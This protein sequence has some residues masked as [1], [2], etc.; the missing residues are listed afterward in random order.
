MIRRKGTLSYGIKN[1]CV[2]GSGIID[3]RRFPYELLFPIFVSG[4]IRTN[5]KGNDVLTEFQTI[6][7]CNVFLHSTTDPNITV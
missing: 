6:F 1:V 4:K 5:P 7:K 3:D 2:K